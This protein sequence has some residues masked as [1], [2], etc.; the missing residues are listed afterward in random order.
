MTLYLCSHPDLSSTSV[1]VLVMLVLKIYL[2]YCKFAK[3]A[4][5]KRLPAG[6]MDGGYNCFESLKYL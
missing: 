3:V 4:V 6:K 1:L 2:I 5:T